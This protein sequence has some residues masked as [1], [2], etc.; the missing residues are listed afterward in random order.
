[1][2]A[3]IVAVAGRHAGNEDV[4]AVDRP[5]LALVE[6]AL[7]I[8]RLE[9]AQ[10][11]CCCPAKPSVVAI[12]PSGPARAKPA[13]LMLCSTHYRAA[14]EGLQAAGAVVYRGSLG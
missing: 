6:E 3:N 2:D 14:A 9:L 5:I 11:A 10:R 4:R 7:W 8:V 12:V 13:D 1:M